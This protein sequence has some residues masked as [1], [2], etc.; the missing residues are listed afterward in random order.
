VILF[1]VLLW[2][3]AAGMTWW[4]LYASMRPEPAGPPPPAAPDPVA[5][6]VSKWMHDWDRGRA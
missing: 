3:L 5:E 2:L 1:T 4:L 6:T